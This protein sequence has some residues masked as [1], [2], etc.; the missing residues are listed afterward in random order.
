L[1]PEIRHAAAQIRTGRARGVFT[2]RGTELLL[3]KRQLRRQATERVA[4]SGGQED[5]Q[6][7]DSAD[8]R[9]TGNIS[10]VQF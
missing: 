10:R 2:I 4:I 8:Q 6:A 9:F 5:L 7:Q 1:Q 3:H